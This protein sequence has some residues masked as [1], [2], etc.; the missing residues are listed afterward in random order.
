MKGLLLNPLLHGQAPCVSITRGSKDHKL[1]VHTSEHSFQS[2]HHG[3][4]V[5][6]AIWHVFGLL[7]TQLR[8]SLPRPQGPMITSG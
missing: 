4:V 3:W 1:L 7:A 5:L 6:P 8:E 2:N